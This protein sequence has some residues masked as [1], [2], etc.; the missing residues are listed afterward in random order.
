MYIYDLI[1][2]YWKPHV[3]FTMD[4]YMFLYMFILS[5]LVITHAIQFNSNTMGC[6]LVLFC[7]AAL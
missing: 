4:F 6:L 2:K 7:A 3:L 5:V 1:K